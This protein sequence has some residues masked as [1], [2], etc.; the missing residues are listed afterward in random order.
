MLI[1]MMSVGNVFGPIS[2]GI[3]MDIWN[4]YGLLL[5]LGLISAAYTVLVVYQRFSTQAL[6]A[7]DAQVSA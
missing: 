5:I 4:P 3:A 6:T 1:F 7:G 2:A